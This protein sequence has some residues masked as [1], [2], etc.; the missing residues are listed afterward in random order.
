[1]RLTELCLQGYKSFAGRQRF[2]FP[3][4][5]TAIIGPNGSGKSNIAEAIRWALG[6]QRAGMLR[7]RRSEELI[8]AGSEKRARAGLAE[9]TLV[10]D[11]N[12]GSLP[13]DVAEVAV[14]RRIHRDGRAEYMLNGARVR[15]RDVSDLLAARLGEAQYTVVGQGMVDRSLSLS[16]IERRALI[17]DAAGIAPLQRQRDRALR[18]L[19]EAE[20]NLIRVED[21]LAELGP[22]L[23][24]MA[25]LGERARR[26][27]KRADQ[28]G[29]LLTAWYGYHW[30]QARRQAQE[31]QL[32]LAAA[33]E[34]SRSAQLAV[35]Q[36]EAELAEARL[37]A[38]R[39]DSSL[40]EIRRN[41]EGAREE[42]AAA[43]QEAAIARTR[44]ESLQRRLCEAE[45][46]LNASME[47]VNRLAQHVASLE[48]GQA[49][50]EAVHSERA[51]AEQAARRALDAVEGELERLAQELESARQEFFEAASAAAGLRNERQRLHDLWKRLEADTA[52]LQA[53]R[54]RLEERWAQ[55]ETDLARRASE[56]EACEAEVAQ[57][58]EAAG[59][60]EADLAAN[61]AAL[62]QIREALAQARS[63]R[64]VLS[65]QAESLQALARRLDPAMPLLAGLA[66]ALERASDSAAAIIG[67]VASLLQIDSGWER[68]VVAAL[69]SQ[70]TGLVLADASTIDA[71]LGC[72]GAD[73][74]GPV[75]LVPASGAGAAW[76]KWE[77][78][79]GELTASQVAR[80]DGHGPLVPQLLG[81]TAFVASLEAAQH[82]VARSGGPLQAATRDGW[83]VLRNGAVIAGTP[84]EQL[85]QVESDLVALP[86]QI[87]QVATAI[88]RLGAEMDERLEAQRQREA[89]AGR[90]AEARDEAERRR[91]SMRQSVEQA[92][93]VLDRA[94]QERDWLAAA[95]ERQTAELAAAQQQAA[96]N[97]AALR[98]AEAA[99]RQAE[100]RLAELEA[101]IA[102][103][104]LATARTRL[105]QATEALNQAVEQ[106]AGAR[107]QLTAAQAQWATSVGRREAALRKRDALQAEIAAG[108][109]VAGE[110]EARIARA[111]A[112]V[113]ALEAKAKAAEQEG[114][115]CRERLRLALDSHSE[116]Q[117]TLHRTQAEQAELRLAVSRAEDRLVRLF[118]QLRA[119]AEW[120]SPTM[121]LP[122]EL[123]PTAVPDLRFTPVADLPEDTE[124]R[125]R[126]LRQELR[127]IG[128]IDREA[129]AEYETTAERYQGLEAQRA[130]IEAAARDLRQML[131]QLEGEMR[132]RFD[133]ALGAVATAFRQT[134]VELFG[135]GEAELVAVAVDDDQPGIEIVARPPGKRRQ[136][137]ALLSGGERALTAVALLFAL[138]QVSGTPFVVLDEVDAA[139]DEAN[140]DRFGQAL[141]EL[142]CRTQ[143]IIVSHNRG[144]IRRAGAV[145][146]VTMA[147]DGCSQVISLRLDSL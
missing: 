85:I 90:L 64:E 18:Q 20:D 98:S 13:M 140:I 46:D 4:P 80:C 66:A 10:F 131:A 14:T 124:E 57:I 95:L 130:D 67:R 45:A 87:E 103:Q 3:S 89:E 54:A 36:R 96:A 39:A 107:A 122:E 24:R 55:A 37:S 8:F 15:W 62:A 141:E 42:L 71:A 1:M 63:N 101:Q 128:A 126:R 83:L 77:P 40:A 70:L 52:E 75:A 120:L 9:V 136:S 68:A 111:E 125:I 139:L 119:D 147:E 104:E 47:E 81:H 41:C 51:A 21:L 97:E 34:A 53:E 106:L 121:S 82:A 28:M 26:Y 35:A 59:R 74:G 133:V 108:H 72:L 5:I 78:Q 84:G 25:R 12:D 6:E 114:F 99:E 60:L 146:G 138:L 30:H 16:P 92:Q 29:A 2:V 86:A 38:E 135:G 79:Q 65:A 123:D 58:E 61:S 17:D 7:A 91:R 132:Q 94:T 127:A 137:L 100:E 129:L 110:L 102:R 33:D 56:L 105:S 50:A 93:L 44:G 115:A 145:Y 48:A 112:Q 142:A 73:F 143:V 49:A 43:R 31:L 116:A 134:F 69:G 88:E 32:R 76:P 11:N 113:A 27:R 23:R 117:G 144:T 118:D 109:A 19:A 22:Q